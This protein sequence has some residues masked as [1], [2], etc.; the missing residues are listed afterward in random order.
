ML[1][2]VALS[3]SAEHGERQGSGEE[4]T[5]IARC[6]REGINTDRNRKEGSETGSHK[7]GRRKEGRRKP[8]TAGDRKE[9]QHD[10][11][12]V[13][14]ECELGATL[15]GPPGW[16]AMADSFYLALCLVLQDDG[17]AAVANDALSGIAVSE[18]QVDSP[19]QAHC[20]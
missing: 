5:E 20:T 15:D 17:A 8:T 11:A 4:E 10:P 14:W 7:G 2:N 16:H 6:W 9:G 1:G 12:T 3:T 18:H 13:V 19:Q